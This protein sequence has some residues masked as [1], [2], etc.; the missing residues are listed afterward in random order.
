MIS[1][2]PFLRRGLAAIGLGCAAAPLY[3]APPSLLTQIGPID[4]YTTA[5]AGA[6]TLALSGSWPVLLGA[7]LVFVVVA[8]LVFRHRATGRLDVREAAPNDHLVTILAAPPVAPPAWPGLRRVCLAGTVLNDRETDQPISL[9][10]SA[11]DAGAVDLATWCGDNLAHPVTCVD[12]EGVEVAALLLL[13]S[14]GEG[15]LLPAR[16]PAPAAVAQPA[17]APQTPAAP[18]PDPDPDLLADLD[19]ALAALAGGDLTARLAP[20]GA[21]ARAALAPRFETAMS[22]VRDMVRAASNQCQ[23]FGSGIDEVSAIAGQITDRAQSQRAA[24]DQGRATLTALAQG[25]GE[26]SASAQEADSVAT[27]AVS[28]ARN[29]EGVVRD[30]VGVMGQISESSTRISRIVSVIE[31][32]AFQTN[33][34]ALNA[35]VEAARAGEAG[36]GFAVVASEVRALAQRSSDAA[37]EIGGLISESSG[38]VSR[39]VGLVGQAGQALDAVLA[40]LGDISARVGA[41]SGA[42]RQQTG[43]A[44]EIGSMMTDLDR[45]TAQLID[46]GDRVT[47]TAQ[48][49][50]NDAHGMASALSSLRTGDPLRLPTSDRRPVA[51]SATRK[52]ASPG[53]A[54]LTSAIRP[55]A[56]LTPRSSLI[57][58][59]HASAATKGTKPARSPAAAA[60]GAPAPL[61]GPG[62]STS[63]GT[64]VPASS[65]AVSAAAPRATAAGPKVAAQAA[66]PRRAAV[67]DDWEEF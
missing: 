7:V 28:R 52:P 46:A 60:S 67:A 45:L 25:L 12:A 54:P 10:A 44:N 49:M 20:G 56:G 43:G 16:H 33:L 29:S 51:A 41:I 30:A 15:V 53:A 3:A 34:L 23:T 21:A 24:L 55:S 5:T 2:P 13:S 32:I 31:D 8:V 50:T 64:R 57:A 26:V 4:D 19:D 65:A 48:V 14:S 47:Q 6:A 38:H 61:R 11:G 62:A 58:P 63:A 22:R 1:R 40:S 39:G 17:C 27:E 59:A 66:A 18:V 36:R 35:G 9:A 37:R 42:V